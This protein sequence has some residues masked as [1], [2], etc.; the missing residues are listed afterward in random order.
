MS[1]L[2]G[3]RAVITGVS[4]GI[5]RDACFAFCEEGARVLGLSRSMRQGATLQSE[6]R[7]L[8][9]DFTFRAC[10]VSLESDVDDAVEAA[11]G[12]FGAVDVL[13][14]NAGVAFGR[15]VLETTDEEW[16]RTQSVAVRGSFLMARGLGR[17]MGSGGSIVN[18]SSTG[19][20][21]ALPNMAAYCASK[22]SVLAMTRSMAVDLAPDVRVNAI[23]PGAIDTP[24]S[25]QLYGEVPGKTVNEVAA[26]FASNHLVKRLGQPREVSRLA[27]FLASDDASF[28]TGAGITVDGG[29]TAV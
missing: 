5:G 1:S 25:W 15:H 26:Q 29:F 22:G 28:M 6:L 2:I 16:D 17:L 7:D 20:L 4:S 13:M 23:C 11:R 24:M 12:L 19:G 21:V 27:A 8:G 18:V 10:D 9:Y 14:N 3:K